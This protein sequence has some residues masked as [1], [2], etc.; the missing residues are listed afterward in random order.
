MVYRNIDHHIGKIQRRL[1]RKVHVGWYLCAVLIVLL[2]VA[3]QYG[4]AI[5]KMLTGQ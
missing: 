4:D 3:S 2:I 1:R 5:T